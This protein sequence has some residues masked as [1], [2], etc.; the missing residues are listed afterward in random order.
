LRKATN[1]AREELAEYGSI[2]D[3]DEE[4]F[5]FVEK[6]FDKLTEE[7]KAFLAVLT[8][9]LRVAQEWRHSLE[10]GFEIQKRI[11]M[12]RRIATSIRSSLDLREV[13]ATAAK[14]LGETLKTSRCFIR[15]YDPRVP[16]RVLA[17]EQEYTAPGFIKAADSIFE[18]ETE[19]MKRIMKGDESSEG[20]ALYL[21]NVM[22]NT[23]PDSFDSNLAQL[24]QLRTFLAVP[25]VYRQDVI[26]G[27]LCFHECQY[28]R[29]FSNEDLEFIWQVADEATVAIAHAQM[30]MHIET[31]AKTDAL[32]GLHNR[33]SFD[34]QLKTEVERAKRS[35]HELSVMMLDMDFL[36]R[37]N[38]TI[39]HTAGDEAIKML[40]NKLKQVLRQVDVVA[41]FG[42]DEFGAILPETSLCDAKNI[43][44]R[45]LQEIL[46]TSMPAAGNLSASI[47]VSGT[48][49]TPLD[50]D[51]LVKRAD[52]ALYLSKGRGK[53]QCSYVDDPELVSRHDAQS[54]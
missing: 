15:R 16:G 40:G 41:R 45:L 2:F 20:N 36:K 26:L 50:E 28:E 29:V 21:R 47:G 23:P 1:V 18:F 22:R 10:Q 33:A 30:F 52:E 19:W 17:T 3:I 42:G 38:D 9:H 13:L 35:D 44:S 32:T 7:E 24:I 53:G 4:K 51:L 11:A 49:V 6:T 8:D 54:E 14:D 12:L 37:I 34:E 48:P 5:L 46:S 39:G 27:S 43:G 31:Q 25:L